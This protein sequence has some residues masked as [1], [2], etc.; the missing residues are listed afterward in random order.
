[1]RNTNQE[2]EHFTIERASP[3]EAPSTK[4]KRDDLRLKLAIIANCQQPD[5]DR[6]IKPPRPA[7]SRIEVEHA[8]SLVEIWHV[9]MAEEHGGK[10]SGHRVKVQRVQVVEHVHIPA[11]GEDD[12]RFRQLAAWALAI[13]IAADS[14]D[15]SD[16]LKFVQDGDFA[17]IAQ[18]ENA[19]HSGQRGGN[20]GAEQAMRI[21]DNSDSHFDLSEEVEYT[22]EI[23][24]PQNLVIVFVANSF[25]FG[26]EGSVKLIVLR[27]SVDDDSL[28]DRC[29]DNFAEDVHG[30]SSN[31]AAVAV[32][33]AGSAKALVHKIFN[34]DPSRM[35]L[36]RGSRLKAI[37]NDDLGVFQVIPGREAIG[38]SLLNFLQHQ[39]CLSRFRQW[40]PARLSRLAYFSGVDERFP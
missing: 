36:D 30:A 15:R 35:I 24:W 29:I 27:E 4:R 5:R 37:M 31:I 8:F 32:P 20:F 39:R 38:F 34:G 2:G 21:A 13:D 40:E 19:L 18:M 6:Q 1:L 10:P 14:G 3:E 25:A 11:A 7:R 16:L 28:C 33:Q 9:R 26:N 17:D 22:G 12:V 23:L